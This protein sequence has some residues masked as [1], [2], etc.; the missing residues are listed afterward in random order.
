MNHEPR[1]S[2]TEHR[3][4]L[5]LLSAVL[6]ALVGCA[7][8]DS[9]QTEDVTVS[10]QVLTFP[11]TVTIA[12]PN[13]VSPTAPV[14]V[15]SDIVRLGPRADVVSGMTV[16]M[17]T[18]GLFADADALLNE[19]WTR[20]TANLRDRVHVR[21]TLHART[22]TL[23]SNVVIDASDLNPNIDPTQTLSW[24]V[25]YPPGPQNDV[26]LPPGDNEVLEPGK[27]GVVTLNSP[28][29]L[30]LR[31]GTYFLKTFSAQ[32]SS[33]IKLDQA[34]GPV[35]IYTTDNLTLRGTFT[36]LTGTAAPDLA[37]IH[38]GTSAV[39]VETLFNGAIVAPSAA[40]T[41]RSVTGIHT[42]Y[43]AAKEPVLD[44]GAR[45]RYRA[46][47]AVIGTASP[48][49]QTCRQLLA[50]LVPDDRLDLYCRDCL[51][52]S[53]IDR[54]RVEDCVDGCPSDPAK[55]APGACGCGV[56]DLDRDNDGV[57][58]CVDK[59]DR[60]TNNASSGE[61]GCVRDLAE[62]QDLKPAGTPCFDPACP[63]TGSTC[64]SVG[65]CGNRSTCRPVAN[66]RYILNGGISY[67]F[68][69]GPA[70]QSAAASACNAKQMH[71]VRI[72]SVMENRFVQRYVTGPTWIGA[73]AITTSGVWRWTT[74][75]SNN[76]DQF[77][78]GSANGAQ[79]NSLFS[80]WRAGN[81]QT[82]RCAVVDRDTGRWVDV[83]CNQ[84][85]GFVCES[86]LTS[87]PRT[88]NPPP[89]G[90]TQPTPSPV[91]CV[92]FAD[93]GLPDSAEGDFSRLQ[94]DYNN[95]Q[96]GIFDGSAANPPPD[97]SNNCIEDKDASAIGDYN[98]FAGCRL[99]RVGPPDFICANNA[100]CTQFGA[101]AVCRVV[102]DDPTCVPPDP[103]P[104]D[105]TT[106]R[107]DI[108]VGHA[109]CGV[110]DC[111]GIETPTRCRHIEICGP[112]VVD[113]GFLPGSDIDGSVFDPATIFPGNVLPD[114]GSVG[115][116]NDPP[117]GTGKL[118]SW[119]FMTNEQA[120]PK[121][122]NPN[123][124]KQGSGGGSDISFRFDP[125]L[126][127]DADVNP[128]AL[129]ETKMEVHAAARL[130][131]GVKVN[132]LFGSGIGFD[133]D[134]FKVAAD[135]R[136]KRCTLADDESEFEIFGL[137]FTFIADKYIFNTANTTI[138]FL[139]D[140]NGNP[141]DIRQ[142]TQ[143]CNKAVETFTTTAHRAKKAFRDAQQLLSQYHELKNLGNLATLCQ[144]IMDLVAL[145][146]GVDFFPGGLNCPA[147]EPPE[148]TIQRFLDYYQAPGFGQIA[149]LKDAIN[150]LVT[151]TDRIKEKLKVENE[152]KLVGVGG[153]ESSTVVSVPF[154]IGPVPML[155]QVDV[156]YAYGVDGIF[157]YAVQ[158]PF[159]PLKDKVGDDLPIAHVKAGVMPYAN[160]GISAFVGAGGGLGGFSATLG[161]SGALSL[162]D[163]K[164]PIFA[165][166][167]LG[168]KI[169]D[170]LRPFE[171][172]VGPPVSMAADAAGLTPLTHFSVP[173]S[174]K[175]NVWFDYGASVDATNVL[176]GVL[177][178]TLRIKFFFFSKEW[179]KEIVRYNGF[180][181]HK[182]LVSGKFGTDPGVHTDKE[183]VPGQNPDGGGADKV[184]GNVDMGLQ[185]TK[186]ALG[187]LIPVDPPETPSTLPAR[188]FD[189]GA[190]ER[191]F[192]D[193]Q[194]CSRPTDP[195][196]GTPTDHWCVLDG[197]PPSGGLMPCCPGFTCKSIAIDL[198]LR[199]API[200][201]SFEADCTSNTDCC[202]GLVCNSNGSCQLC[203]P[204][205]VTCEAQNDCC[206][207]TTCSP[208]RGPQGVCWRC[209][210][211]GET[212][213]STVDC[214][215]ALDPDGNGFGCG[216]PNAA[217]V[218]VC[219]NIQ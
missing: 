145:G 57:P 213:T 90:P 68:C 200:C 110:L 186:T 157:G 79:R 87:R 83:D 70:T 121:A 151:A 214:C 59:C 114:A 65:V 107:E 117:T 34:G 164:I 139:T 119:C 150:Q 20:G 179:R 203:D 1:T 36:P 101:N 130:V 99:N 171:D 55:T 46:P 33:V 168:A 97:G 184:T 137:D 92:P 156:Y 48:P 140:D 32:S 47:L 44:A 69:P 10:R 76:G 158:F 180:S 174:F 94:Q 177:S 194:C 100:S 191:P 205:G 166:A 123:D 84:S 81:P 192:Y 170:D 167:G 182:E 183:T 211:A 3:A 188:H 152:I 153:S 52:H 187:V 31:T 197:Q 95:A 103:D 56:P 124:T 78:Q 120:I 143:A 88:T 112:P 63:Q 219:E 144:D 28:S 80:Y 113:A 181:F 24:K 202:S 133:K 62:P 136:A 75:T 86:P 154:A 111:R 22:R 116:Y 45:V 204:E 14:V 16:S 169:L 135:L 206:S 198:G 12:T 216:Q 54:D 196:A 17:G 209:R 49:G 102:Q 105:P 215:G 175:F 27:Y 199:C 35:I 9:S 118:H 43:F 61:C 60:D 104:N 218:R 193:N 8:S 147:N 134:I 125:D 142:Q 91:P 71:L 210:T 67:W 66:C 108:C 165:G 93:S 115:T 37:L 132:N 148:I 53:D 159:N 50:G 162:A 98:N 64:N 89:G 39:F 208:P 40:V 7:G 18:P 161:V 138:K 96:N 11:V 85:L 74:P 128:L 141:I 42:G 176:G 21:G 23:G 173:K 38:L 172:K 195:P 41:L 19:T 25:S 185:E 217:G 178:A 189:A 13:P 58:N 127:F 77:W 15:G 155:L 106:H 163:I 126:I 72:N 82:Q 129:G 149:A 5:L 190:M 4:L 6:L 160:A 109:R 122:D 212:C 2:R 73:N 201:G 51:D 29:T 131:A 207:G 146:G 26:T 30:T